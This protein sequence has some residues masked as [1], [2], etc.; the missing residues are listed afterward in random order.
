M[1]FSL[2]KCP[3]PIAS[4]DA[5]GKELLKKLISVKRMSSSSCSAAK[6]ICH[7]IA[8]ALYLC[9]SVVSPSFYFLSPHNLLLSLL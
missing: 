6:V 7:F 8:L 9:F 3:P 5:N 2:V 1:L 4:H